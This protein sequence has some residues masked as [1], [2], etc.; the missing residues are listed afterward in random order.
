[1]A[2]APQV[3]H[4]K[5]E[6]PMTSPSPTRKD[7]AAHPTLVQR[8]ESAVNGVSYPAHPPTLIESAKRNGADRDVVEALHG[9][10][11]EAFGSFPEVAASIAAEH[12]SSQAGR[13]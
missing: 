1:M 13:C 4:L 8:I 7:T 11:D 10:P 5:Q 3:A 12:P 9:L 2:S 6:T